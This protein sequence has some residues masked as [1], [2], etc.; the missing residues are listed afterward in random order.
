VVEEVTRE[1][2]VVR[3][4]LTVNL[5]HEFGSKNGEHDRAMCLGYGA[6]SGVVPL[7]KK[8]LF[9]NFLRFPIMK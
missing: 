5:A 2:E 7:I 9:F 1:R 3:S 4:N 8:L 6:S